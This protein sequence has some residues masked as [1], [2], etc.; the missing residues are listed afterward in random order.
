MRRAENEE[1]D[2]D[3]EMLPLTVITNICIGLSVLPRVLLSSCP[4]IGDGKHILN[5]WRWRRR[6]Y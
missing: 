6:K 3:E 5:G 4:E 1:M 2:R